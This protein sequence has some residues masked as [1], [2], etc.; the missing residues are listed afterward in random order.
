MDSFR[1][2]FFENEKLNVQIYGEYCQILKLFEKS[3]EIFIKNRFLTS[4]SFFY[5]RKEIK[6]VEHC[7]RSKTLTINEPF[8]PISTEKVYDTLRFSSNPLPNQ[9]YNRNIDKNC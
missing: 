2:H 8:I 7:L 4:I 1:K 5:Y 9:K 6:R 3:L